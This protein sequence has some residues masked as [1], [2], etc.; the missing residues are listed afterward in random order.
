MTYILGARCKDG[1]VL[2]GDRKVSGTD[3]EDPYAS[4]IRPAF[5]DAVFAAAGIE[6]VFEDFLNELPRRVTTRQKMFEEQGKSLPEDSG[7]FY[8]LYHFKQDC[9][10]LIKE[11]KES[12]SEVQDRGILAIQVLIGVKDFSKNKSVLYYLDSIDCL[13]VEI[14]QKKVIGQFSLA[15]V[16]LKSWKPEMTMKETARLGAFIIKY[17]EKE[18][19]SENDTVGIGSCQPQIWLIP[20]D[21]APIEMSLEDINELLKD[22]DVKVDE[23]V[24][25]IGSKGRFLR[26]LS[27]T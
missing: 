7:F 12:C 27:I 21:E 10:A 3:S 11:I 14:K 1:V 15:D 20:D 23:T 13:P 25:K 6:T 22:V 19:L 24:E 16:F 4:K 9:V 18:K 26:T 8:S 17:I 5:T 2:V